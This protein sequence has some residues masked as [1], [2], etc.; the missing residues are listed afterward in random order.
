MALHEIKFTY[1][2]TEWGTMTIDI[3]PDIDYNEK[4]E[5]AIREIE[6]LYDNEITDIQISNIDA[7]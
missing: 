6:D 7:N 4:V 3:D 2:T 1:K 5:I